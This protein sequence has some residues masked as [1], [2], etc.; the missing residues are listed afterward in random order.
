MDL[1]FQIPVKTHQGDY[2]LEQSIV[3][4]CKGT[5]NIDMIRT[6]MAIS[7][8]DLQQLA[9]MKLTMP[10]NRADPRHSSQTVLTG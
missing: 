8:I 7:C 9:L 2:L 6:G 10:V 4:E 3:W 5:E 1:S